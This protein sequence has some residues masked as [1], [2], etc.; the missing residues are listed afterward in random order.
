MGRM[1]KVER[2][3]AGGRHGFASKPESETARP[4]EP[5]R[6]AERQRWSAAGRC[7]E[8]LSAGSRGNTMAE[9]DRLIRLANTG[10]FQ[11]RVGRE[12]DRAV[13][14]CTANLLAN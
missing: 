11:R 1:G 4:P 5:A 14:L 2:R 6:V 13:R 8:G 10:K 9:P 7:G 3:S 12:D